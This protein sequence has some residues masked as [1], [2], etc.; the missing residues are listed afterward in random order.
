MFHPVD[1]QVG[2]T[3]RKR[4]K[5]IGMSQEE[6]G[7]AVGITFQQVQK[8]ERGANRV[9]CSR[10]AAIAKVLKTPIEAF[11]GEYGQGVSHPLEFPTKEEMKMVRSFRGMPPQAQKAFLSFSEVVGGQHG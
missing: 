10:L 5:M 6:L 3:I 11:F 7:K 2:K 9:S 4:R 1:C 8:Y